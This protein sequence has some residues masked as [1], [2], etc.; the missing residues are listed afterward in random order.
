MEF[1]LTLTVIAVIVLAFFVISLHSKNKRNEDELKTVRNQLRDLYNKS[2]YMY[3]M[4]NSME[5][6]P[7]KAQKTS[8][9]PAP[10]VISK[11]PLA[12][13]Q[14]TNNVSTAQPAVHAV[15]ASPKPSLTLDKEKA[16]AAAP[17]A[18]P[19]NVQTASVQP[20]QQTVAT[21]ENAAS[22]AA[23]SSAVSVNIPTSPSQTN[24]PKPIAQPVRYGEDLYHSEKAKLSQ[25]QNKRHIEE[26]LGTRLFNIAAS[27]LI[28]IGLILF[29]TLSTE[30]V[31]NTMKMAA[32]FT[33]SGGFIC[34]GAFLSRKDK[35]IFPLGMLGCGFGAFFISI[36]L[37]HIYFHS[38]GDIA[39]FGLILVWSAFALFMSKRLNSVILSVTAHV[40]T[41][42]S[43]CFAFTLGF[44]AERVI[45]L[46]IYQLAAIA[47]III[48]NI[49]C[50]RKTY[51]FGLIMSQCLLL[52]TSIAMSR[53]FSEKF[54]MPESI[55][56]AFGITIFAVQFIAVSFVS[57][58]VS[59]SAAALEKEGSM[60]RENA[61]DIEEKK[62]F[63]SAFGLKRNAE[64]LFMAASSVH[65]VNKLLWAFGTLFSAGSITLFVS[66]NVYNKDAILPTTIALCAAA[67]LHLAVTLFLEE[68]LNF[69]DHLATLSIW[70][71]STMIVV[72]LFVG[73]YNTG[74]P[75][76]F[77]YAMLLIGIFKLTKN[78]GV[79]PI[80]AAVLFAE[81]VYMNVYGY[82][83][84]E[85]VWVSI[86]YMFAIGVVLLL[87]WFVQ[88]G[89]EKQRYFKYMKISEYLWI[90]ASIISINASEFSDISIPLIIS[91]F[92]L[93]NIIC[94]FIRFGGENEPELRSVVKVESLLTVYVGMLSLSFENAD[95]LGDNNII[96]AVLIVMVG[97]ITAVYVYDFAKSKSTL[98]RVVSALT[99]SLYVTFFAIGFC[100]HFKPLFI[101]ANTLGC[102]P[103]LFIFS[104]VLLL[105]YFL[106][107]DRKLT[108]FIWVGIVFD[109]LSMGFA[110]YQA[111]VKYA[112][113]GDGN[114]LPLHMIVTGI[115][116]AHAAAILGFSFLMNSM[117]AGSED[118]P[119]FK[120][121]I[122]RY[123]SFLWINLAFPTITYWAFYKTA[124]TD[125]RFDLAMIVLTA[126][127]TA[128]FALKYQGD[129]GTPFNK[130][131]R[132]VSALA[133]YTALPTLADGSSETS[134]YVICVILMLSLAALFFVKAREIMSGSHMVWAQV[135][136]GINSTILVNC[137]CSGLSSKFDFAYIF[138]IVTMITA[139]IC[140]IVGF[141]AKAKGLRIYGLVVVMLCIIK[142]VTID[143]SGADSVAR[144]LAFIVGGIICFIISGIYNTFEK[145]LK[146]VEQPQPIAVM[147]GSGAPAQSFSH[148]S[149]Q[150]IYDT[151]TGEMFGSNP[152]A[153]NSSSQTP[154]PEITP[155]QKTAEP[156]IESATE[157]PT[158][159]SPSEVSD[160]TEDKTETSDNTESKDKT[161]DQE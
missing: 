74:L 31:T 6:P 150:P 77:I 3:D 94:Y 85:N 107:K 48:G 93:M 159:D 117:E 76:A 28:F 118:L 29:C 25:P 18:Q 98:L 136:I 69:S 64:K 157:A 24:I 36:L 129:K 78:K 27:L 125:Y 143:I 49:F 105:I 104:S 9:G 19:A 146:I 1:V 41:A 20:V 60:I 82:F 57:Y 55:S 102:R 140:I 70:F 134:G 75:F 131:V 15:E 26:W 155:E 66:Q 137:S 12:Y 122:S 153:E 47:V 33:V 160:K 13:R 5:A 8:E 97:L 16:Q 127:N 32:M 22:A 38:L 54:I 83:E 135:Y 34:A 156:V 65:V 91:E 99:V 53:A 120:K 133:F 116:L 68:K 51:R 10:E 152:Q 62:D 119:R 121:D 100:Q 139:L 7:Q 151:A 113:D 128:V 81:A 108:T 115:S 142:L 56:A 45:L 103:L 58:L 50:C 59:T 71:I 144:V 35:S 101:Y 88:G 87:L 37:S 2:F 147:N 154:A 40:G 161:K 123:V 43:I 148:T 114:T 73:A 92:A 52:Y 21:D 109:I 132:V 89:E 126:V 63:N 112:T 42:V 44:T 95:A 4:I 80:T 11:K 110:G 149:A 158:N 106:T 90:S 23:Q 46:T 30:E 96:K 141:V 130:T 39:A 61:K 72:S 124:L 79:T 17:A 14:E 111:L 67:I 84:A 86:P 145:R 138:S